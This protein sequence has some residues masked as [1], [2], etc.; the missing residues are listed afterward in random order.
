MPRPNHAR[1]RVTRVGRRSQT[2]QP[3]QLLDR[4]ELI[5]RR[6]ERRR[7]LIRRRWVVLG[8]LLPVMLVSVYFGISYANYMLEPTSETF[9]ERSAEWV[10]DA[11][12][13]GNSLIARA[14]HYSARGPRKGGPART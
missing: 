2:S 6:T 8:A 9:T 3:S 14:E 12:P 5:S 4:R 11:V 1:G 7:R 13:F 10:R